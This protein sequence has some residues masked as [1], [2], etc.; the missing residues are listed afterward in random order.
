M[1][2]GG[3]RRQLS[4]ARLHATSANLEAASSRTLPL[5]STIARETFIL[6]CLETTKESTYCNMWHVHALS[7]VLK[8]P[9]R[10]IYPNCN[11]YVRELL[12]MPRERGAS[13][14]HNEPI[15]IMWTRVS[16]M[17]GSGP[18][19]P[20]HFI[21]CIPELPRAQS[22]FF[23][24]P[25]KN[26]PP[27]PKE[28]SHLTSL[29]S[30]KG[31]TPLAHKKDNS[32]LAYNHA[33]HPQTFCPQEDKS[34]LKSLLT[35]TPPPSA[36]KKLRLEPPCLYT[37][38]PSSPSVSSLLL[39]GPKK[40]TAPQPK[41]SN[42]TLLYSQV[43]TKPK[44]HTP[45]HI[46]LAHKT[47]PC[48]HITVPSTLAPSV[49]EMTNPCSCTTPLPL[50]SILTSPTYKSAPAA[51]SPCRNTFT[52][53]HRNPTLTDTAH[54]TPT[55][56]SQVPTPNLTPPAHKKLR[57]QKATTSPQ[58]P[59]TNQKVLPFLSLPKSWYTKEQR[60][61]NVARDA[62]R[63]E[64]PIERDHGNVIMCMNRSQVPGSLESNLEILRQKLSNP[65]TST[66]ASHYKAICDVG[67][68]ILLHGPLVKT[69]EAGKVYLKC[70][71]LNTRKSSCEY[72]EIFSRHL[73]I[74]QVYIFDIGYLLPNTSGRIESFIDTIK[75]T[76][77]RED[78]LHKAIT[79]HLQGL[80][81]SSLEYMDTHGDRTV[82]KALLAELTSVNFAA[83][84]QGL[85]SREGT[86]SAKR[87]LRPN[88]QKYADIKQASQTVRSDLTTIQQHHLTQRI[89]TSRKLKE[90]RT[91][92]VA[93]GRGRKL[94]STE[95][96]ELGL[97]L[98][99]AFGELDTQQG[100]G[101]LEAHPRLTIGT[102]YRGTDNATTMQ[103]ARE[104]LLAMAPRGFTISLSSCYN[105][106]DNYRQG[107]AQAKR[108]H[109]GQGVN[110]AISLKKPPRT[111]VQELVVNLHWSTCNVNCIIDRCQKHPQSLVVSKDA[112]AI[113][114]ADIAPVQLPGHS[115][116]KRELP[117][118]TWDQSRRNAITPMTFLFL[119]TRVTNTTS[120]NKDTFVHITRSGQGVTLLNLSFFEP[121]TT[122][123]CMNEIF[124]LLANPALDHLFRDTVTGGL[125]KEFT[126][127]VDNRE[128]I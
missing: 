112:K 96:P 36:N 8:S 82:L 108:H 42:S 1:D 32:L 62:L 128:T 123:K 18:W 94:K 91:I 44:S 31:P 34:L 55:S 109:S 17:V 37:T 127:V 79:D 110:A 26:A 59:S 41:R 54:H 30:P 57:L 84:L 25:K 43:V 15:H 65:C 90:I 52:T 89:I 85:Q 75:S 11:H 23:Q 116:K 28:K 10:S 13:T 58:S 7:S 98:E 113:V 76:V 107:S 99:Y 20:N 67:T 3:R 69:Q 117:E 47:T 95:F 45:I 35:Y 83:K 106:T 51:L 102:L 78:I 12:V 80:V 92:H 126:F 105:Y 72:Y 71:G 24:G 29:Y 115:W 87:A 61:Y 14:S 46:P 39:K 49:H 6:D 88:L 48:T 73:N 103:Q 122:F 93:E 124:L 70:K 114:M 74:I 16:A 121:D 2:D 27:Q 101:G 9:V 77:N 66:K 19:S 4:N 125:K 56:M 40:S 33:F 5:D 81:Q 68:L 104:T 50:P 53:T 118:H 86:T 22:P 63:R 60:L 97:A 111:G 100:G 120:S 21:P 119:E 64:M 38:P